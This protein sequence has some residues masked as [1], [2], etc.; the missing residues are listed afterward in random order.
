MGILLGANSSPVQ[1]ATIAGFVR[2]VFVL[3]PQRCWSGTER[4]DALLHRRTRRV[5]AIRVRPVVGLADETRSQANADHGPMLESLRQWSGRVL[6]R[7]VGG[8]PNG[9][10]AET[11]RRMVS[12]SDRIGNRSISSIGMGAQDAEWG[13]NGRGRRHHFQTQI[14]G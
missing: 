10:T 2:G 5:A 12:Q 6:Y 11:N 3:R 4:N 1:L 9:R 7:V 14:V 13:T 8:S